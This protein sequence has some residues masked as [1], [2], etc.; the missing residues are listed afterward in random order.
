VTVSVLISALKAPTSS[1]TGR[2][3]ARIG[4]VV[5]YS[6]RGRSLRNISLRLLSKA[7]VT[8]VGYVTA[9]YWPLLNQICEPRRV[10]ICEPHRVRRGKAASVGGLVVAVLGGFQCFPHISNQ[11]RRRPPLPSRRH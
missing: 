10:Q 11:S 7:N 8:R 2:W 4:G 9:R 3:S 5:D 6:S 1:A